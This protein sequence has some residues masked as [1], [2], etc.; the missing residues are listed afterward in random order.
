MMRADLVEVFQHEGEGYQALV[1]HEGWRV[2][3][4]NDADQFRRKNTTYLERHNRTD[5]AFILLEG[6]CALYIGENENGNPGAVHLLPME[7][8][9]IY[10]VKRGVWHNLVTVPD[11]SVLIVENA[12]TAPDNSP[13]K[14]VSPDILPVWEFDR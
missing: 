6:E 7:K 2:A 8:R 9:R 5:E 3:V 1:Y 13:K 11:S 10:N 4:L 12:D 14:D